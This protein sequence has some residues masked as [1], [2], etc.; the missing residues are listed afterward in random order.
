MVNEDNNNDY[1]EIFDEEKNIENT[2][3]MN[4]E[5]NNDNKEITEEETIIVDFR[6]DDDRQNKDNNILE[7]NIADDMEAGGWILVTAKKLKKTWKKKKMKYRKETETSKISMKTQ[8][9][10][11]QKSQLRFKSKCGKRKFVAD[12]RGFDLLLDRGESVGDRRKSSG[13]R[14]RTMTSERMTSGVMSGKI[15]GVEAVSR[16]KNST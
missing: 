4:V 2:E 9:R 8:K 11:S 5:N 7:N 15:S 14:P 16:S 3:I 6:T 10:F 13:S 1:K 12:L